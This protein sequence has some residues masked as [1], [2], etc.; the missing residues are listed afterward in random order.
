MKG[1]VEQRLGAKL[2]YG[3]YG[4]QQQQDGA[5]EKAQ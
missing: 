1:G 3:T 5:R 2:A 4:K